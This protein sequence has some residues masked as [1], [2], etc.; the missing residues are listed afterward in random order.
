MRRTINATAAIALTLTATSPARAADFRLL[1]L[2]DSLTAG[3]GLPADQGFVPRLQAALRQKGLAV[4]VINAGVSGDT[5][6]DGLARL[7]WTLAEPVDGAI[8]ELGA[9]DGLRGLD[10]SH[11]YDNLDT[12]LSKFA[13]KHIPVLLAGMLA[14]PNFGPEYTAQFKAVF[15]RLEQAHKVRFY[16]FFLDGVAGDKQLNQADGLHPNAKGVEVVVEHILPSVEALI[17]SNAVKTE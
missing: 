5:S 11:L 12:V 8:L 6:A 9:N 15:T 14:P 7:D 4:T 17:R 10:T 3:Y 2:G 13:A 1:A 16:P